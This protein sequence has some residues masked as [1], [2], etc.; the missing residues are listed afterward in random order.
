[1]EESSRPSKWMWLVSAV[2]LVFLV[3][4]LIL[5]AILPALEWLGLLVIGVLVASWVHTRA[6]ML[7]YFASAF[8][9]L[10]LLL[11]AASLDRDFF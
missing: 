10:R 4:A 1:M 8:V 9:F 7:L 11:L 6:R 2:L 5:S 3:L